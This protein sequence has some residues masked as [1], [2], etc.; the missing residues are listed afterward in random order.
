[1]VFSILSGKKVI[2]SYDVL[3]R[4]RDLARSDSSSC[5]ATSKGHFSVLERS[6][7]AVQKSSSEARA[8]GIDLHTGMQR[9]PVRVKGKTFGLSIQKKLAPGSCLRQ[10]TQLLMQQWRQ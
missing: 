8:H 3:G 7:R 2:V 5:R 10:V 1:M 4:T 9:V 6:R